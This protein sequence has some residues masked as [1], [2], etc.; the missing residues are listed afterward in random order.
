MRH[1][2][3]QQWRRAGP[4]YLEHVLV[5]LGSGLFRF[6]CVVLESVNNILPKCWDLM[7][8]AI[9]RMVIL[10]DGM[11]WRAA[12]RASSTFAGL[13]GDASS[14]LRSWINN[15]FHTPSSTS[16][17]TSDINMSKKLNPKGDTPTV[18]PKTHSAN[19]LSATG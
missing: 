18:V 13:S 9:H 19:V 8:T 2:A 7:E 5:I 3:E 4:T 11:N 6:W 17:M 1:M 10:R 14:S 15:N 12:H 16:Y